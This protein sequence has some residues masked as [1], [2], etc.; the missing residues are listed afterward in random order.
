[1]VVGA[2]SSVS[3]VMQLSAVKLGPRNYFFTTKIISVLENSSIQSVIPPL[4]AAPDALDTPGDCAA[5]P[6]RPTPGPL[7]WYTSAAVR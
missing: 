2:M 4:V 1:M 6:T 7:Q 3:Q 5:A